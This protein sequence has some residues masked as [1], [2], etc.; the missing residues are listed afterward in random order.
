MNL[1]CFRGL[2]LSFGPV[3]L[4]RQPYIL[5]TLRALPGPQAQPGSWP[6]V[7][8]G[9]LHARYRN[10]NLLSALKAVL[11]AT[12]SLL[13]KAE[14]RDLAAPAAQPPHPKSRAGRESCIVPTQA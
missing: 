13:D 9:V 14:S 12:A 10:T 4:Q 11:P 3:N 1:A 8:T 6:G 2:Y 7:C 5:A